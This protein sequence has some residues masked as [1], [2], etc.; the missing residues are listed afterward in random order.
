VVDGK[1]FQCSHLA[2]AQILFRK[3]SV[4][5]LHID[6]TYEFPEM[7][8]FWDWAIKHYNLNLIVKVNTEA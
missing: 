6:T 1:R 3:G 8:E 4:P 7:L 5:V 2:R